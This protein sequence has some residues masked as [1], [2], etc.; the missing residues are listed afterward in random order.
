MAS[1]REGFILAAGK[2]EKPLETFIFPSR[3]SQSMAW[4]KKQAK[5]HEP[6]K[7]EMLTDIQA[8]IE[9]LEQVPKDTETLLPLF[10]QLEELEKERQVASS[11]LIPTNLHTQEEV[12]D[13]LL[14]QYEFL[15]NDVDINGIRLKRIAEEFLHNLGKADLKELQR[16]K[17][18]KWKLFW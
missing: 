2:E 18:Q 15:Q 13:K 8:I 11:S 1:E 16:E 14:D 10:K 7:A 9:F 6:K 3:F 4:W 12:L 17:K 5:K